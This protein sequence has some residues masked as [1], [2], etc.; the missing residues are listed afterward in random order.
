MIYLGLTGSIGM[1]KSATAQLFRDEGVPV[2]D[3][4]AAVHRIYEPGGS[5]VEAIAVEFPHAIEDGRVNRAALREIVIDD[6]DLLKKLESIVHPLVGETQQ[7]FRKHAEDSGADI[8]VLDIPLLF[9]T[10]GNERVDYVAVVTAPA[11]IQRQ[12]VMAREGMT[13]AILEAI[14]AKQTPDA[15]KR[16]RADFIIN[17]VIDIDYAREQVRSLLSAIRRK[18]GSK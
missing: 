18:H 7:E 1:G 3:A 11:D 8:A 9:E 4:D 17:T 6:A 16:A 10:G 12:R 15:E 14:L 2:Y 13:E 5:A